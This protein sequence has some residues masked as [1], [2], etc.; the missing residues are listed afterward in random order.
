MTTPGLAE[1]FAEFEMEVFESRDLDGG[2]RAGL[3]KIHSYEDRKDSYLII[4]QSPLKIDLVK[5]QSYD[6]IEDARTDYNKFNSHQELSGY[7]SQSAQARQFTVW[8]L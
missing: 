7:I 8:N 5:S 4:V 2:G 3:I 1:R 6:T